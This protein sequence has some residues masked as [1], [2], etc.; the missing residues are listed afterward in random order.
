VVS[1]FPAVA[2]GVFTTNRLQA[3]PV[4]WSRAIIRAGRP[5]RAVLL[6]SGNANACTGVPGRRAVERSAVAVAC[7]LAT[8]PQQVLLAS[9]GVIGVPL[10]IER[11]VAAVPALASAL[12]PGIRAG[13]RAAR[14]ILTTDTV[15]KQHAV[16]VPAPGRTY[17]V[18]GMAKGSGMIHPNMATM[19]AVLTC[20]APLAKTQA[21]RLLRAA[22][23]PTF[24]AITVDGDTSTN[25]CVLL[26]ANGA[27]GGRVPPGSAVERALAA[28][29]GEVCGKLAEAIAADAEGATKLLVVRVAGTRDVAGAQR[30]ARTV[31]G[32]LLVKTAVHG[33]DPNWGRVLAAAGAAGVH[34]EPE[35]LAL[36][37]GP[38]GGAVRVVE[39]GVRARYD[40]GAAA[41]RLRRD[42]VT[43][44]L[45]LGLGHATAT[46]W[47]CDLSAKYVSINAEYTT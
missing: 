11:L 45:D 14:A 41:E 8:E 34:L 3:A 23:A 30:I 17:V 12:A 31:A 10:P 36:D 5:V 40:E 43:I 18:G 27:A 6:N 26:L 37:F 20:D 4:V 35:R 44:R 2:A 13:A 15:S 38:A 1:N 19:L 32:S 29:L 46:V 47:T 22:V 21:Q 42:P 16:R 28:A 7:A 39:R 24:N 33:G 9:T 25:D